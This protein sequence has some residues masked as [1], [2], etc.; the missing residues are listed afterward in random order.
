MLLSA[1]KKKQTTL[2]EVM[3]SVHKPQHEASKRIEGT[4]WKNNAR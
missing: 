4:K 1:E 2:R 3:Q